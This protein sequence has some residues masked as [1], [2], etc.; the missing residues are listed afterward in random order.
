MKQTLEQ[1][2][3]WRIAVAFAEAGEWDT[4]REMIPDPEPKTETGWLGRI[5]AAVAF[6]EEG[7]HDEALRI[8]GGDKRPVRAT[9]NHPYTVFGSK[10]YS[11]N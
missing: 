8:A 11:C 7:L 2:K 4:A 9:R 10:S 5:F 1:Y 6:A 3:D